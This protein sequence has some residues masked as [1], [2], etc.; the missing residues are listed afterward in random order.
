MLEQF[1]N[2]VNCVKKEED[3][4]DRELILDAIEQKSSSFVKYVEAVYNMELTTPIIYAKY[5]GAELRDKI[6]NLDHRRRIC[7]DSAIS[8]CAFFNRQCEYYN[9]EKFCP[10]TTDRYIIAD[11]IGEFV[12]EVY[13]A[14][15]RERV[16]SMDDMI[17]VA[18]EDNCIP[19]KNDKVKNIIK[20]E[21]R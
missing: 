2:L 3:P 5:D 1:K 7:H 4:E 19:I 17:K 16:K 9:I 20:G 15:T 12:N 11:F 21:E 10:E 6:E 14:G 8:A 13:L 18:K